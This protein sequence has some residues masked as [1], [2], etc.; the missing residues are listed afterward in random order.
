[1]LRR[2]GALLVRTAKVVI[3]FD[4]KVFEILYIHGKLLSILEETGIR[5]GDCRYIDLYSEF[6][7]MLDKGEK[8]TYIVAHLSTKYGVSERKVYYLYKRF[9]A[10]CRFCAAEKW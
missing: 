10:D 5:L 6:M 3:I 8:V 4:M 9:D 2:D 7:A 1:V